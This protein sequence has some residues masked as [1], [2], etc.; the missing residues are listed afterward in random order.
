[1][2][3]SRPTAFVSIQVGRWF[4]ATARGWGVWVIPVV[5][6]V[7]GAFAV[8]LHQGYGVTR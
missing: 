6:L 7:L 4:A 3:Q 5:L 8:L 1:M 2:R